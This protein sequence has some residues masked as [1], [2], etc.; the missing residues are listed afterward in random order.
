[1]ARKRFH[2]ARDAVY[3]AH[4]SSSSASQA[5]RETEKLSK[6]YTPEELDAAHEELYQDGE[7]TGYWGR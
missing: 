6:E 1:M 5:R 2:A 4:S 3:A 7:G